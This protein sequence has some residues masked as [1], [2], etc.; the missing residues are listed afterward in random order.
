[1]G[2]LFYAAGVDM[3]DPATFF[4]ADRWNPD[5]YYEQSD[6][7]A[8][9]KALLHGPYGKF[10][11]FF[12]PSTRTIMK[13][14]RKHA[15]Q[16]KGIAQKYQGK[17]IKEPRFCLT[18]PAWVE[19]GAEI[20][21]LILCLREPIQVAQSI[22]RRDLGLIR[23]GLYLWYTHNKTLL[24]HIGNIPVWYVRY[25][26]IIGEDTR[27]EE[28]GRAFQFFGH[29]LSDERLKTLADECIKPGLHNHTQTT[30][31]YPKH[32]RRLW[33]DLCARHAAQ[34]E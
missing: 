16:L 3:G 22:Q 1:M 33:D 11:Y 9:N 25:S 17:A 31:V 8:V 12:L 32:I 6:V 10:A 26:Y 23:H 5:G 21:R 20:E 2:Q 13:R 19:H 27:R 29:D 34:F 4:P 18:L 28:L 24:E 7:I 14:A 30:H 15:E